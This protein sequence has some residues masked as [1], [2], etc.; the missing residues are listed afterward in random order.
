M[1]G[2]H[3]A[4]FMADPRPRA[5]AAGETAGAVPWL[6]SI[7]PETD[8]VAA[9]A[10]AKGTY[11]T[12]VKI[13]A[14][15]AAPE[16]RR[17]TEEAH[18]QGMKVWAH[19]MVVPARPAEVV[20]AG[21]DVIS[22]VCDIA[23]EAMSV[24]P[25]RYHHDMTPQYGSFTAGSAVFTQLF[26]EMRQRGIVLD[27]TLATY[28][29]QTPASDLPGGC[30]ID[31]ARSLVRRAAELGVAV[32]AGSDF[33]TS[34]QD[35]YPALHVELE[36]LVRGGGLTSMQ[37]IAAATTVAAR[38]I[39]IEATHGI[40]AHGRPVSFVLLRDDPLADIANL[41]SVQAVWKNAER[42]DRPAY[43]SRFP[44]PNVATA[45]PAGPST[46]QA[47]LEGWLSMW[48]EYDLDRVSE[49]FV[50]DDA[51]SYFPSDREGAIEGLA[52]VLEYHRGL[53]FTSGGFD[54]S[55]ELW[56]ERVM[57][58]DFEDSAVVTAIWHFG[59][60]LTRQ[61]GGRGPLTMVIARTAAGFRISHVAFGN[62]APER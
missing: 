29:R 24:V 25:P 48:R 35:P 9:V 6:Q 56:L 5:A 7:T 41:R 58:S 28:A 51:L 43:R 39:G 60:R 2:D 20:S 4:Q 26:D 18:R 15:L 33:V 34:P 37:A 30:N 53:G 11:A 40:L 1:C 22:H 62:Y 27:A 3:L 17:I 61:I 45:P 10:R 21:V 57:I 19:S 50:D 36:E 12:G 52:A 38:T 14:D 44:T 42:F 47:V 16:V 32:A 23:W 55:N 49:L 54:P 8:I 46:P 59:A 13:H 31:F